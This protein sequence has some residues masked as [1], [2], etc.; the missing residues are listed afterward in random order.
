MLSSTSSSSA[1]AWRASLVFLTLT[2]LWFIACEVGT[3]VGVHRIS[4]IE[5]GV[6]ATSRRASP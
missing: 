5:R 6:H 1:S 4:K 2:G 3:R